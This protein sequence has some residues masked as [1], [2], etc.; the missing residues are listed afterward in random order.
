MNVVGEQFVEKEPCAKRS[1]LNVD[2][3]CGDVEVSV[4][5]NTIK[6]LIHLG[7]RKLDSLS[8]LTPGTNV[9]G[10]ELRMFCI[11]LSAQHNC[12]R[13]LLRYTPRP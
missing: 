3:D 8:S 2:G 9:A 12:F 10:V 7:Q 4:V 5:A 13:N 11:S 1:R 6:D